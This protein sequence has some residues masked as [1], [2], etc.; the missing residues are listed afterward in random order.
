M[1]A[2]PSKN[3]RKSGGTPKQREPQQGALPPVREA[4]GP[5]ISGSRTQAA[6]APSTRRGTTK[7]LSAGSPPHPHTGPSS[8]GGQKPTC[9]SSRETRRQ[10]RSAPSASER[11]STNPRAVGKPSEPAGRLGRRTDPSPQK[12]NRQRAAEIERDT[13]GQRENPEWFKW[14]SNRI[15]AS[16]AHK[17]SHCR[18]VNGK[19]SE[20]PQSYLKPI[21]GQGSSVMTPAMKWGINHEL[22]AVKRY[23]GL[24]SKDLQKEV[25]VRPCGL[26]IDPAK[27]WLAASPDGLVVDKKTGDVVGLLEVKC[28]YKHRKH[29]INKACEDKDFCLESKDKLK[30]NHPYFTQVQC[31]M[32]VTGIS[33]TDFVVYTEQDIAVVPVEFNGKFWKETVEKLED[34]YTRAVLPEIQQENPVLAREE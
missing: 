18:F 34:F 15:T 2:N 17:I 9:S 11:A 31:Q 7:P 1:A 28:P 19:S 14:R 33:K 5:K 29:S 3:Q 20:V 23:E 12:I 22:D 8:P 32:A 6:G 25:E 24:K 30:K 13:R 10:S 16:V 26:F 27:N 4:A 21:L